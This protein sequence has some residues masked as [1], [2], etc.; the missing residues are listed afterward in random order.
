MDQ[1][2]I[3]L[4][5]EQVKSGNR[6]GQ[7]FITQAWNDMTTSFNEQFKS[8][9]DKEVLKNRYK[10]LRKQFNDVNSLLQQTGFSWDDKREIV[11]AEDHVWHAYIKVHPE[12]RSLR[13][14]TL[15]GYRRLCVIF[16]EE[17]SGTRYTQLSRNA[18]PG[19]EMPLSIAGEH[20]NSTLHGVCGS[21][22]T[23]DWTESMECYFVGLMIEQVNRGNMIGNLFNEQAW[24][25]LT[26]A[27]SAKFGHQYD[28]QFL[29]DQYFCLMKLHGDIRN[30]LSHNGFVWDETLQ[31]IVAENDIWDAYIKDH[32]DAISYRNRILYLYNDLCEVFGN[33]ASESRVSSQQRLHLMDANDIDIE[34][35]MDGNL[36]V[37]DNTEILIRDRRV[38]NE[39]DMVGISGNL[40]VTS[41]NRTSNQDTERPREMDINGRSGDSVVTV[42]R[43]TNKIDTNGLCRE[44][45]HVKKRQ[46]NMVVKEALS[47]M[48]SVVKSLMNNKERNNYNSPLENALSALQAM[49]DIDEELVMDACDLLEDERMAKIFLALDI[50]LRKKW[51]LRKLR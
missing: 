24:T 32:P 29:V 47:E 27:F 51:L 42:K 3:D 14:K 30:L 36:V 43:N 20:K 21:A 37:R 44:P 10:H 11:A 25:H 31:I 23:I 2:L 45:Q 38:S 17:C 22:S 48:A 46:K 18:D 6:L 4:L 9:C 5:L 35:D 8:Q 33:I 34:M 40:N 39:I 19:C 16:G 15:P 41:N 50:S 7:T 12:A 28:K 49:P 13:V 1:C 26:E